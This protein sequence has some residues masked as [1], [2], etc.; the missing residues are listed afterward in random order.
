MNASGT[1]CVAIFVWSYSIMSQ[2]DWTMI[3]IK[4]TLRH[5]D[6]SATNAADRWQSIKSERSWLIT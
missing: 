5:V 1:V 3:L 2:T 6:Q 4:E